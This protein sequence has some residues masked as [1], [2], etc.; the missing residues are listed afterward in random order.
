MTATAMPTDAGLEFHPCRSFERDFFDTA[1]CRFVNT[2][3]LDCT[4]QQLFEVFEDPTSWPRWAPGIGEV[5]WTS[6]E[7]YGPGTT[8]T[9]RF[10]GGM[11]VYEDFFVFDAPREMAFRFYGTSEKLWDAFGELYRVE[12]LGARCRLTWTVAYEAETW[13]GSWPVRMGMGLNF[14]LYMALLRRHCRKRFR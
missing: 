14:K 2:V 12:D 11:S 13:I 10:W 4:P 9:V 1:A 8:R 7:P 3:E 5:E 6:P